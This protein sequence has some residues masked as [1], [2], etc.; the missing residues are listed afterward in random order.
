MRWERT[1]EYQGTTDVV[2]ATTSWN[3]T[4]L[5]QKISSNDCAMNG[6]VIDPGVE[7]TEILPNG[8]TR[9]EEYEYRVTCN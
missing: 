4:G 3:G 6:A 5:A 1:V 8:N 7:T 9:K 2:V